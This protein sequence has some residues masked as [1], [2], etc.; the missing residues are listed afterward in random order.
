[1]KKVVAYFF[2][3]SIMKSLSA[4]Q[5]FNPVSQ[6]ADITV[7]AGKSQGAIAGSYVYNWKLGR[8]K[9]L[10]AGLGVRWT[11]YF[12]TNTQ[13]ITAPA[14]LARTN[15]TPFIIVFA[16]QRVAYQ[17]TLTV[18]R[19][20]T[21]SLNATINV[22]H[23]FG[24]RWHAGFNIDLVGFSI[25]RT[26]NAALVTEGLVKTEPRAKPAAFNLLLTGDND[27]GSLN[28]EFFLKYRFFEKWSLRAVYQFL[29]VEYKTGNIKQTAPDG[30][31]TNRFRNKANIFGAGI[32]YHL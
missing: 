30:T 27:Y 17:D 32:S 5:P 29:F 31:M 13:F 4:Q 18:N 12:G 21:S 16:G 6:F 8:R 22:G 10:E 11:S 3:V 9:R 24:N 20:M 28:S 7:A 1:M 2:A 25:G 15:T 19:A 14:G 26:S 23:S